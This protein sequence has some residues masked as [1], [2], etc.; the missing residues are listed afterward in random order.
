MKRVVCICRVNI[1]FEI[2]Y[3]Y[4]YQGCKFGP[5]SKPNPGNQYLDPY[6]PSVA[7]LTFFK[8]FTMKKNPGIRNQQKS[9]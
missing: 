7:F 2:Y 4:I 6:V 8:L 3:I 5:E 1:H 9:T